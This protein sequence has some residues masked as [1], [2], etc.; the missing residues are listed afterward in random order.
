MQVSAND[1]IMVVAFAPMVAFLLSVTDLSVPWE[2]LVLATVL[3]VVLPLIAGLVTRRRLGSKAAIDAVSARVKPW[4]VVG[5]I[6]TVAILFGFRAR[7]SLP[8]RV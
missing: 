3:Y 4:F 8:D 7:R 5:L 1:L 6:A 2:T